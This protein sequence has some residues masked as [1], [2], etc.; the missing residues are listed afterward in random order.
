MTSILFR[1]EAVGTTLPI[2]GKARALADLSKAGL[3]VPPWFVILPQACLETFPSGEIPEDPAQWNFPPG[4]T[5]ALADALRKTFPSPVPVA[6]RSSAV[7]EDGAV[8]SFAGMFETHLFV[9]SDQVLAHVVDI[10]RSAYSD[11]VRTYRKEQGLTGDFLPPAVI[12]QAMVNPDMA[13]VAF[14]ADPITGQRN[15]VVISAV[16]GLGSALV[17]GESDADTAYVGP[18]SNLLHYATARKTTTHR[19]RYD[20]GIRVAPNPV[21][22]ATLPAL[23]ESQAKVVAK[24]TRSCE[25]AYGTPQDIEWAIAGDDLW[26][27]QSRPITT[28]PADAPTAPAEVCQWDNIS[29][30]ESWNGPLTPLTFSVARLQVM[31]MYRTLALYTCIPKTAPG[32]YEYLF[33]QLLQQFQGQLYLNQTRLGDLWRW[34]PSLKYMISKGQLSPLTSQEQSGILKTVAGLALTYLTLPFQNAGFINKVDHT[35]RQAVPEGKDDLPVLYRKLMTVLDL[36][37]NDW[38]LPTLNNFIAKELYEY[39]SNLLKR[40]LPYAVDNDWLAGETEAI[41]RNVSDRMS[42]MAKLARNDADL[43]DALQQ[44]DLRKLSQHP[45]FHH[46]FAEYQRLYGERC[47][48]DLKMESLSLLEDPMPILQAIAIMAASPE[49]ASAKQ[50][51]R[52][53]EGLGHL[54]FKQRAYVKATVWATRLQVRRRERL[55]FEVTRIMD[56]L[57]SVLKAIGKALHEKG[58]FADAGD[59]NY[60]RLSEIG[61]LVQSPPSDATELRS[62]IA[63]RRKEHDENLQLPPLPESFS[64]YGLLKFMPPILFSGDE[65]SRQGTG[66]SPGKISGRVLRLVPGQLVDQ[67]AMAGCI[68][69]ASQGDPG[70]VPLFPLVNG[71]IFEYGS[72][73]SHAAIVA[74]ELQVPTVMGVPGLMNWL[75]DGEWIEIDGRSG[76]VRRINEPTDK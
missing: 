10:W 34:T 49:Q 31:A 29:L 66:C 23:S 4:F 59:I 40:A 50:A 2:G 57:R 33:P 65:Q 67:S 6:V 74:R 12:V 47:Q 55:R 60:L 64:T 15:V 58:L 32:Q 43:L 73:L 42:A 61:E 39:T 76:M 63:T 8:H 19:M 20:G 1:H 75:Q 71:L 46:H 22:M 3:P 70:L 16:H 28:L 51:S 17:S 41:S 52:S 38:R 26:L 36:I 37:Q 5:D 44:L 69:I 30:A 62:R 25:S 14:S 11:R 68:L 7:E 54:S 27:L 18:D 13:G 45:Q 53:V 56:R 21:D 35:L 9:P 48:A 24:L 72:A